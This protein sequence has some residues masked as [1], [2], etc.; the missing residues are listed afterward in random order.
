MSFLKGGNFF[1]ALSILLE[2][3]FEKIIEETKDN[4]LI[5]YK[6]KLVFVQ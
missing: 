3:H 2:W 5:Q 1:V 4:E 6:K